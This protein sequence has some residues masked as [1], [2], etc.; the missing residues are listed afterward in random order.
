ML[1]TADS[2]PVADDKCALEPPEHTRFCDTLCPRDCIVSHWS[3]WSDCLPDIC[4]LQGVKSKE[5]DY[6]LASVDELFT[7]SFYRAMLCIVR[8]AFARYLSLKW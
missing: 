6:C 7:E 1:V 3:Q 4:R 8:L 5:G 2:V